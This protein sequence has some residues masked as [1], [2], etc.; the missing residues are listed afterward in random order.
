LGSREGKERS[1]GWELAVVRVVPTTSQARAVE[2]PL[3][4][5]EVATLTEDSEVATTV[6]KVGN[7]TTKKK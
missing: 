1:T 4:Q 2:K 7:R 6:V 5:E 3:Q